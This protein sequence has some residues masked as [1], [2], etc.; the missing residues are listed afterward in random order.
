MRA[1]PV[2]VVDVCAVVLMMS[3][4]SRLRKAHIFDNSSM[5]W[6]G[7]CLASRG[8]GTGGNTRVMVGEVSGV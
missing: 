5:C 8:V 6:Q 7:G 2:W 4:V 1:R 3:G